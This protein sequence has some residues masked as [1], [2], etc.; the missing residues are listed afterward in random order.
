MMRIG[1]DLDN[2]I[3]NYDHAFIKAAQQKKL[4]AADFHGGKQQLRDHIRTL[5]DGEAEWQK[6][7]GYV[8]GQ[9]INE[10]QLFEGVSEFII[11]AKSQ[12]HEMFIVSH[13]TVQGHFD[14]SK[15]NLRDAARNFLASQLFAI[16]DESIF[17]ETT[18]VEKIRKIA[19]LSLD[20]FID[21]LPEVFEETHFPRDIRRILFHPSSSPAPTGDWQTCRHW[22][23]IKQELLT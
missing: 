5:P 3:I 6:L 9:G 4:I 15:T 23:H 8:Y 14:D 20:C 16:P 2:T 7:Q 17:F 11:A 21:D 18:R 12:N 19:S 1:I 10:A 22:N 13:K